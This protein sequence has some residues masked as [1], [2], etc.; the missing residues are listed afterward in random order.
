[1]RLPTTCLGLLALALAAPASAGDWPGW[2]GPHGDGHADDKDVPVKWSATDNV[3]WKTP[4]PG[5]GHSSPVVSGDR[6]FLTTC[7]E[8][9]ARRPDDPARR[10]LLCLDRRDGKVLWQKV[11]LSA[12]L[13]RLHALNSRASSTPA[14]DGKH[15]FVT[16]LDPTDDRDNRV[17]VG[18]YD[19]DGK[20]VWQKSPGRFASVHGF[21]SSPILYKDTVIVNCDHDGDGYVVA[22]ARAT[23]EERWRI[24]R[25]NHTRSYCVPLLVDA[26]GRKQMVLSGSK[27]VAAYDPDTGKPRWI[28]DGP[29]EQFVSSLVSL[30]GVLFLTAGFPTHHY[31]A[32]NPDG[33][34]NV[35]DT[36]VLW[37]HKPPAREGAYVPSPLA[38]G[39]WFFAVSDEGWCNCFDAK[40]GERRWLQR[41]GKHH[42]ASPVLAN[43]L[44]YFTADNGDTYVV[45]AGDKFELVS[46]NALGEECRA[47]PAVADGHIFIRGDRHLFCIGK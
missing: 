22:L 40:S 6:V 12:K 38:A 15:V 47:S 32:I 24:E 33:E 16:F 17:V 13:E 35:T 14:A 3:A 34:G 7:L 18:C 21:C 23:G 46:K 43:G 27:C 25:P 4:I 10:L 1:M 2:R 5:K 44:L 11:V 45:K 28:I 8:E 20:Q 37:H 36:K 29:T 9:D 19:F 31:L 39:R 41:L 30:D 26:A 42:S